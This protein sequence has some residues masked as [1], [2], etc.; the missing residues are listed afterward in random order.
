MKNCQVPR[1]HHAT[2]NRCP[3]ERNGKGRKKYSGAVAT[4]SRTLPYNQQEEKHVIRP[5]FVVDRLRREAGATAAPNGNSGPKTPRSA[6]ARSRQSDRNT[7][8]AQGFICSQR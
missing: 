1:N 5:A 4:E 3:E 8:P 2:P 6:W 7:E